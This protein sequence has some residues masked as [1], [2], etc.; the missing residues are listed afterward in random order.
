MNNHKIIVCVSPA[1]SGARVL[2]TAAEVADTEHAQ[3]VALYVETPTHAAISEENSRRLDANMTLA[4][5]LGAR[6]ETIYG[7][8]VPSRIAEYAHVNEADTVILGQSVLPAW[9]RLFQTPLSERLSA[10]LPDKTL[11]IIPDVSARPQRTARIGQQ[12]EHGLLKDAI[13]VAA[14]LGAATVLGLLFQKAGLQEA[15]IVTL[16]IL[17]VTL[18]AVMTSSPLAGIVSA[19]LSVVT[20]N[21]LFT[22]PLFYFKVHDPGYMITFVVMFI[23]A[24]ITGTLASRLKEYAQQ[25][26]KKAF[27]TQILLDTSR[28]LGQE[29]SKGRILEVT[30][31]QLLKL[32]RRKILIYPV[33]GDH[34][35]KV[36]VL[37]PDIEEIT[38]PE[39]IK[40]LSS[41]PGQEENEIASWV[42]REGKSAGAWTDNFSKAG[43]LFLPVQIHGHSYGVFAIGRGRKELNPFAHSICDSIVGECALALENEYNERAREEAAVSV[44]NEQ[45]RTTLLR[46]ISHD[47][48]TP[49]TSIYGN[50]DNLLADNGLL[51]EETKKGIYRDIR[52]DSYWLINVVQNLLSVTR[53]ENKELKLDLDMELIDDVVD[54]ALR[55]T[56]RNCGD[57]KV[58][59]VRSRDDLFAQMDASL[60]SQV[61]IN[62]VNNA[63]KY[64]PDGSEIRIET[65]EITQGCAPGESEISIETGEITPGCAPGESEIRIETGEITPGCAQDGSA[66]PRREIFVSVSD[67]G[68]GVREEELPELFTLF[69]TGQRE[70]S[71]SRRGLGLGLGVCRSVV[72]AHGGRIHA[73]NLKPHGL[74]IWFTLPKKEIVLNGDI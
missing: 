6:V 7:E 14:L 63:L 74:R 25:S 40:A 58:I 19:V 69:Y 54:E 21:Y 55:H 34:P 59:F 57:R 49:L 43:Y 44:K 42:L 73:Q 61:I 65:G 12:Q 26:S 16:Y 48:R 71:D 70:W 17:G 22:E 3:L 10:V 46:S 4:A 23:A 1:P 18:T 11:M 30:A 29:D 45:L 20:F 36:Q 56:D 8:D 67:N 41:Q 39:A 72:E 35:G 31:G 24:F 62:L 13:K 2:R 9:K 15:N 50:A 60:I 33:E 51:D 52:D 47:L 53:L 32:T 27:R 38:D 28:I 5:R 66:E 64:T 37:M 68:N